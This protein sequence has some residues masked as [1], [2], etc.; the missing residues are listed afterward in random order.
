MEEVAKEIGLGLV[1]RPEQKKHSKN[2]QKKLKYENY[3]KKFVLMSR[4]ISF[5]HLAFVT[6][7]KDL[8]MVELLCYIC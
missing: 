4:K 7:A 3:E 6:G 8:L 2:I 5:D 1:G